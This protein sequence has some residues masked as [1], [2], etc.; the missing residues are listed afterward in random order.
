M[1]VRK[2]YP[3]S[4]A[5]QAALYR[6][7]VLSF[8]G[9]KYVQAK[10]A[11]STVLYENPLFEEATQARLKLGLAEVELS[12]WKEAE[13]TLKPLVETLEGEDKAKAQSA[14]ARAQRETADGGALLQLAVQQLESATQDEER[15]RAQA[16]L[17]AALETA[18]FL[19]LTE[20]YNSLDKSS[21]AWPA[22]TYKMARVYYHV[23]DW[24]HLEDT[25]KSLLATAP[26][27]PFAAEA[28]QLLDKVNRRSFV[29][30][31]V[32]GAVLPMSGKFKALGEAV[33]RG[34]ALAMKGSDLELVVKDN[35]GDPANV[36]K[37]VEQ[38]AFED[39]AVAIVGPL[40]AEDSRRAALVAE[41]LQIP[42]LSLARTEGLTDIGPHVFRTMVTNRQ[43]AN[44]LADYAVKQ[45]G[46][47]SFAMLF[48]NI[49]FGSEFTNEFW[50]AVESRGAVVKGAETYEHDQTTFT[51][52]AKKLVGRYYL[53]DRGDYFQA[54]SQAR[55]GA[56]ND[57]QKRKAAEKAKDT[58]APIVDFDAL[59]I[60]D[61]WQ[62]VALV[63]PALAVEDVVTNA[64]DSKDMQRA[65]QTTGRK[66]KSVILL[67]P[68]TWTS[69]KGPS[70]V[71][72]LVE[73][74]G[75]YV[76]CSVYVDGFFE[77]SERKETKRFV[78]EFREL[79]KDAPVTLLD[80][81]A[82]D[83]GGLLRSVLESQSPTTREGL[84]NK[85]SEVKGFEGAMGLTSFDEKREAKRPLFLLNVTSS[86]IR[87]VVVKA[88][89]EG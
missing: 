40:F 87:E 18:P 53:E 21:P 26:T 50:D 49:P 41:E 68:S 55:E 5:G 6:A 37:L 64:C 51:T 47:K 75:K 84:R 42:L 45:L 3:E 52:E 1:R 25:L 79:A 2:Q 31:R 8:E 32:V 39:G 78:K 36:A 81:V 17:E 73:R 82:Y 56:S 12:D 11:F 83:T 72:Q 89:G 70:G 13:S 71:P 62:R 14:L 34:L 35:Q 74:G 86:G 48:P 15:K 63:A 57:L 80:A 77:G 76:N 67:G 7:G 27:S 28:K 23:R 43:Q 38:L 10:E 19:S 4:T 24:T 9:G 85:L 46:F 16:A 69:P 59:L 65:E 61:S 44:V 66:L 58:V 20:V 88:K 22:T 54:L 30:P 33:Q 60:P 29:K